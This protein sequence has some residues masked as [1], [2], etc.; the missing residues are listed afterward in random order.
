MST[1]N[2]TPRWQKIV[3]CIHPQAT[4]T[5]VDVESFEEKCLKGG[6]AGW[7]LSSLF[8]LHILGDEGKGFA[9]DWRLRVDI[10]ELTLGGYLW[11]V[12]AEAWTQGR[13]EVTAVL[14]PW[15]DVGGI[16]YR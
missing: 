6:T 8:R 2:N 16:S 4:Y 3:V 11:G 14:G 9:S 13:S 5:Y 15:M 1:I 10:Q 7:Y 12:N